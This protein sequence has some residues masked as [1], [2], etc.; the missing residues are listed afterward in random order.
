MA[1]LTVSKEQK[2]NFFKLVE[3]RALS[4]IGDKRIIAG[5]LILGILAVVLF[6]RRTFFKRRAKDENLT[7]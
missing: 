3:K 7:S 4:V 2:V 6:F 1:K 5:V